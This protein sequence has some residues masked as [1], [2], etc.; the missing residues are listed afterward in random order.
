M[1][2]VVFWVEKHSVYDLKRVKKET[3]NLN[4]RFSQLVKRLG[5][6]FLGKWVGNSY[7]CSY[8]RV[9]SNTYNRNE[10]RIR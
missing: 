7:N 4:E 3:C 6:Y 9:N 2:G 5:K 1:Y 8:I 10:L